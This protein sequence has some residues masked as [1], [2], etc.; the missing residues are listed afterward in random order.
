MDILKSIVLGATM[1]GALALPA[2][3]CTQEMVGTDSGFGYIRGTPDRSGEQLWK[4]STGSVVDWCGRNS[5]DDEGITWHWVT[6]KSQEEPW[7]HNGWISSRILQQT[8]RSVGR[9]RGTQPN[10][11]VQHN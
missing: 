11:P 6:F 5:T 3:A 7:A 10:R 8:G 4:L 1:A 2:Y 9:Y